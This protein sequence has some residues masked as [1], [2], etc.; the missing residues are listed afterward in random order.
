MEGVGRKAKLEGAYVRCVGTAG[1]VSEFGSRIGS[2]V[3][4]GFDRLRLCREWCCDARLVECGVVG[5][6]SCG[7][8]GEP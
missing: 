8:V 7:G 1:F 5:A 2:S 6:K 4:G 3:C